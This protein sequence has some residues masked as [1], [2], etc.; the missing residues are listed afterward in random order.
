M[1]CSSGSDMSRTTVW[2]S[3][4]T[5]ATWS[6]PRTSPFTT[7]LPSSASRDRTAVTRSWGIVSSSTAD[8]SALSAASDISAASSSA[9]N[10]LMYCFMGFPPVGSV[11]FAWNYRIIITYFTYPFNVFSMDYGVR[12]GLHPWRRQPSAAWSDELLCGRLRGVIA[13]EARGE[14]RGDLIRPLRGHLPQR[15]RLWE[16]PCPPESREHLIRPVPGGLLH[17]YVNNPSRPEAFPGMR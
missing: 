7:M 12:N 6:A 11:G 3:A 15:G 13:A 8:A 14:S 1:A 17:S 16:R 4:R 5:S 10:S 9:I 2:P